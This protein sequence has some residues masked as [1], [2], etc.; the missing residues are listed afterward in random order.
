MK[1]IS[2]T[3]VIGGYATLDE[4]HGQFDSGWEYADYLLMDAPITEDEDFTSRD[5]TLFLVEDKSVVRSALF[6][7]FNAKDFRDEEWCDFL[8]RHDIAYK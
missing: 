2:I 1:T 6:D 8:D 7:D 5:D 3:D 4:Y